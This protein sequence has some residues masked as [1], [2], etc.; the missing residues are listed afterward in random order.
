MSASTSKS[1]PLKE[2]PLR[3]L[4]ILDAP[5]GS[6]KVTRVFDPGL[7]ASAARGAARGTLPGT[8]LTRPFRGRYAQSFQKSLIRE[9]MPLKSHGDSIYG[10]GYSP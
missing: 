1:G 6:S 3:S 4:A 2:A 7:E 8:K 9:C 5:T 10:L